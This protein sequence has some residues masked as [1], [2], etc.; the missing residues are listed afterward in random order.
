MRTITAKFDSRCAECKGPIAEDDEIIYDPETR[1]VW[2]TDLDCAPE[3]P[4]E[5]P[6]PRSASLA[7]ELG[8]E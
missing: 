1:K 5:K 4:A 8:F 7:D 6:D 2:H 3:D